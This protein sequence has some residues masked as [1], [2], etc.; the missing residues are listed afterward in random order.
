MATFNNV[1]WRLLRVFQVLADERSMQPAPAALELA[2]PVSGALLFE[3]NYVCL[4]RTASSRQAWI[5]QPSTTT[6]GHIFVFQQHNG[7]IEKCYPAT[8]KDE[9]VRCQASLAELLKGA[10]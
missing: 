2:K 6:P 8:R 9:P 4:T 3:E 10:W 7:R 1:G 5:I